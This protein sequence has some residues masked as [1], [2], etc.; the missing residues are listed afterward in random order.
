MFRARRQQSLHEIKAHRLHKQEQ[1]SV[2]QRG[3]AQNSKKQLNKVPVLQQ[4]L[5]EKLL[6]GPVPPPHRFPAHLITKQEHQ[7]NLKP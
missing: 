6:P 1:S 5:R 3:P 7:L 2:V 4:L